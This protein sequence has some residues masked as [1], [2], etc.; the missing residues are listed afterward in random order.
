MLESFHQFSAQATGGGGGTESIIETTQIRKKEE[1]K[2]ETAE[3]TPSEEPAETAETPGPEEEPEEEVKEEAPE[4]P[5]AEPVAET[6]TPDVSNRAKAAEK[7]VLKLSNEVHSLRKS[8]SGAADIIE[9]LETE[10]MP[11]AV[12]AAEDRRFEFPADNY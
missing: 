6:P 5:A 10:P 1:V 4:E 2:E 3:E 9:E 8:L 12:L 11:P 7:E